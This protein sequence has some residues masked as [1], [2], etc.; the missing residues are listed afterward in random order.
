MTIPVKASDHNMPFQVFSPEIL[1]ALILGA[2]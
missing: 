2:D 1:L